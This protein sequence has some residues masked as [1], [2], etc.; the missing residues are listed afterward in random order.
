[1]RVPGGRRSAVVVA[2]IAAILILSLAGPAVSAAKPPARSRPVHVRR[3]QGRIRRQLHGPEHALRRVRQVPDHAVELAGLGAARTSATRNA[4]QTPAN[5]EK[6][7]A[8]KFTSLYRSL[9]SWRRVAYWWLTGSK[10]TTRLVVRTPR[11]T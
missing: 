5:Q 10:R 9:G 4:K 1:M 3:R 8:G 11:A 7:A 2:A 6:V